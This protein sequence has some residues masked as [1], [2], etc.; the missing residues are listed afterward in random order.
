VGGFEPPTA[1]LGTRCPI[2]TR[3]HA[4]RNLPIFAYQAVASRASRKR[5]TGG[6]C[7]PFDPEQSRK[8]RLA[9]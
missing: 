7:L 9:D 5:T 3:L 2:Q 6:D 4:P 8:R 1:G